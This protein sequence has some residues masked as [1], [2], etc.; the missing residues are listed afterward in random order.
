M[1]LFTLQVPASFTSLQKKLLQGV[2]Q[3]KDQVKLFL[4]FV[5]LC[6]K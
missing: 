4:F 5:V 6:L 3:L 1:E 2:L